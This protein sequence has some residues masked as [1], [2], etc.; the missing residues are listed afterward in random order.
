MANGKKCCV[1]VGN[2]HVRCAISQ[3]QQ[4]DETAFAFTNFKQHDLW[5]HG[6]MNLPECEE[7]VGGLSLLIAPVDKENLT[8]AIF[9]YFPDPSPA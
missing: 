6:P 5:T 3:Q 8:L 1:S 9:P 4:R 2:W 7:F